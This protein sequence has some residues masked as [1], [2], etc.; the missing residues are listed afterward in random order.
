LNY[1]VNIVVNFHKKF[2]RRRMKTMRK[3]FKANGTK[4]G[5]KKWRKF[6]AVASLAMV[7]G[8]MGPCTTPNAI[9]YINGWRLG[10]K[11]ICR[12]PP[13]TTPNKYAVFT[14]DN[15]DTVATSNSKLL[16]GYV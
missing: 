8:Q 9:I 2:N 14:P 5:N 13:M 10:N 15:G 3:F 16:A 11:L 6:L 12:V 1:D 7:C 4:I